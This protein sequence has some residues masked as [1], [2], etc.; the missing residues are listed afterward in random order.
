MTKREYLL[1]CLME[2]AAEVAQAASKCIRFGDDGTWPGYDGS[3]IVRLARELI[4]FMVVSEMASS[5]IAPLDLPDPELMA[6]VKAKHEKLEAMM[7]R[8]RELGILD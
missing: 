4:D 6:R 2:E 1:I 7:Q 5:T 8:A 3:C